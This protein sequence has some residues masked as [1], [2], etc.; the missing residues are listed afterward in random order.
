MQTKTKQADLEDFLSKEINDAVQE[1]SNKSSSDNK[2][3]DN[4]F[5]IPKEEVMPN[6]E[7][8][9]T[10][11][12]FK[13][14]DLL[15]A[16]GNNTNSN[17]E[18][19]SLISRLSSNVKEKAMNV[20]SKAMSMVSEV[21][22]KSLENTFIKKDQIE[23]AKA[24]EFNSKERVE[25]SFMSLKKNDENTLNAIDNHNATMQDTNYNNIPS[26]LKRNRD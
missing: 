13:E 1:N 12:P 26:F 17:D 19:I 7:K 18:N 5:F 16:N 2:N 8:T 23:D 20:G 24:T 25:P 21:A 14:A 9:L 10:T 11:N 6:K 3:N 22:N 4:D 15:N